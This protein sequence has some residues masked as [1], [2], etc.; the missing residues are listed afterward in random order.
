MTFE[1]TANLTS[2][3]QDKA[4]PTEGSP[5]GVKAL[6]ELRAQRGKASSR[7]LNPGACQER[8]VSATQCA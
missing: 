7:D 5:I 2:L 4:E 6:P 8:L 1:G 3:G